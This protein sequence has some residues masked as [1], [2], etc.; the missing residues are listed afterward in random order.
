[1]NSVHFYH[2][3]APIEPANFQILQ[4]ISVNASRRGHKIPN[5][6]K[7]KMWML[8]V[9]ENLSPTSLWPK[10]NFFS[11]C[12]ECEKTA[13]NLL[14]YIIKS[15]FVVNSL[16]TVHW[17]QCSWGCT[18]ATVIQANSFKFHVLHGGGITHCSNQVLI[19]PL[20]LIFC[21]GFHWKSC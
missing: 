2:I 19:F 21:L 7:F 8:R 10:W 12:K 16:P 15:K 6:Q 9:F 1:M 5:I 3:I 13:G 11:I 18:L 14:H 17:S 4:W 20:K